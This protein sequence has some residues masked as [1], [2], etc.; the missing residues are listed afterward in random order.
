MSSYKRLGDYIQL[1]DK[2]NKDLAVSNQMILWN[3]NILKTS[4][5]FLTRFLQEK[6]GVQVKKQAANLLKPTRK[7]M[8]M[9]TRNRLVLFYGQ[10]KQSG[11]KG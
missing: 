7:N 5:K 8:M 9:N 10:W 1:V 11:M 3:V 2:R 4:P 6:H